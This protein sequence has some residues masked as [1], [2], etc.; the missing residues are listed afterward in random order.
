MQF[1]YFCHSYKL[2]PFFL[3]FIFGSLRL[4]PHPTNFFK[5]IFYTERFTKLNTIKYEKFYVRCIF[6]SVKWFHFVFMKKNEKKEMNKR[7][8]IICQQQ[9]FNFII[10]VLKGRTRH[11]KIYSTFSGITKHKKAL[12]HWKIVKQRFMLFN[13]YRQ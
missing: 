12:R 7:E 8:G 5:W 2:V 1:K 6:S 13:I 10:F 9:Q 4:P 3:L 11:L